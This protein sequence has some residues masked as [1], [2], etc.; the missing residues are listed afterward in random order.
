MNVN[1]RSYRRQYE[2]SL[3]NL[4]YFSS[5][6]SYIYSSSLLH[7]S[8]AFEALQF[9]ASLLFNRGKYFTVYSTV[10]I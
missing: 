8:T 4:F 5:R 3:E 6:L 9:N 7:I 1:N 10:F 2:D